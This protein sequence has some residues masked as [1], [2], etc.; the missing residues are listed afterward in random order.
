LSQW[1]EFIVK[2]EFTDHNKESYLLLIDVFV[3]LILSRV[4]WRT[5]L[6]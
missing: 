6:L 3:L 5:L 1:R 2:V 4:S